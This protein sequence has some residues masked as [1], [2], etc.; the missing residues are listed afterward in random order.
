MMVIFLT[1]FCAYRMLYVIFFRQYGFD[2]WMI[3]LIDAPTPTLRVLCKYHYL[4]NVLV[5]K[6]MSP[7]QIMRVCES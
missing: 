6:D 4:H 7:E 3:N 5:A 1:N 2:Q